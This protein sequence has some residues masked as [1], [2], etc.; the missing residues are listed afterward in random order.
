MRLA[1]KRFNHFRAPP[2][3]RVFPRGDNAEA[4]N[5]RGVKR[6]FQ[7]TTMKIHQILAAAVITFSVGAS[8]LASAQEMRA[9]IRTQN[10]S[11]VAVDCVVYWGNNRINMT[12]VLA[13]A[14]SP[15]QV[16]PV[17]E[18]SRNLVCKKTGLPATRENMTPTL[19]FRSDLPGS[20]VV[21]C[22]QFTD[23]SLSCS[24]AAPAAG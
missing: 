24:L 14:S 21:T 11:P 4:R 3:M 2:S 19:P 12:D 1:V 22:T 6:K 7:G 18:G 9:T 23:G 13:G 17:S 16:I 20:Y 10:E 8:P 15:S 5:H